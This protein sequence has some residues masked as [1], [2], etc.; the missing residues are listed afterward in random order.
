MCL[1]ISYKM[2]AVT[3]SLYDYL[4]DLQ[5]DPQLQFDFSTADH[6]QAHARSNS[7][8]ISLDT[9]GHPYLTTMQWGLLTKYMVTNPEAMK[10]YAN[11][12]FN[13]RAEN[14]LVKKSTWYPLRKNRC[15]LIASGIYEHRK[16]E[17]W[18]KKAP[19]FVHLADRKTL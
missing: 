7:Q 17:G 3:D 14:I 9:A 1:D 18:K 4:P 10:M 19:Y 13:A 6:I 16:I 15:L 11:N 5:I 12:M 2:D 8:I